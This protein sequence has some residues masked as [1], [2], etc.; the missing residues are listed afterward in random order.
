MLVK[1]SVTKESLWVPKGISETRSS[2]KMLELQGEADSIS[3]DR[4]G[5]RAVLRST[6][7]VKTKTNP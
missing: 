4:I 7:A 2:D 1:L 5:H 3:S 6:D